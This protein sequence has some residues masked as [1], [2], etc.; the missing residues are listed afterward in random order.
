[1]DFRSPRTNHGFS[2]FGGE[3]GFSGKGFEF[4]RREFEGL[5]IRM[6]DCRRD[7]DRADLNT[8]DSVS[9]PW[10]KL[11]L[12]FSESLNDPLAHRDSGRRVFDEDV[13]E[14][15]LVRIGGETLDDI[16]EDRRFGFGLFVVRTE[17]VM[18]GGRFVR[19]T[20][21]VRELNGE[22]ASVK[23]RNV[24]GPGVKRGAE[25]ENHEKREEREAHPSN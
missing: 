9:V 21:F 14:M 6:R 18:K 17:R 15:G 11:F 1:L 12:K 10:T 19:T 25:E 8:V 16:S 5:G 24:F 23:R 13:D 7:R 4:L 3:G 20:V 22:F 2:K